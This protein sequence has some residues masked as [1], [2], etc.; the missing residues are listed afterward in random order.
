MEGVIVA[1]EIV[2]LSSS[3][4]N[5]G[6]MCIKC[7]KVSFFYQYYVCATRLSQIVPFPIY[8]Y[9]VRIFSKFLSHAVHCQN[10]HTCTTDQEIL[11]HSIYFLSMHF[12]ALLLS[13]AEYSTALTSP[14]RY[15]WTKRS[16]FVLSIFAILQSCIPYSL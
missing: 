11:R 9:L 15:T 7:L 12:Y 13:A 10:H 3:R 6:I 14:Y 5:V 4:R 16:P 8:I 2:W 1:T